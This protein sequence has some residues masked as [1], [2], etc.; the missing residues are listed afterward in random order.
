MPSII[1]KKVSPKTTKSASQTKPQI[2]G[3]A[4]IPKPPKPPKLA[5]PSVATKKV[6]APKASSKQAQVIAILS[7]PQGAK[8]PELMQ[9]TGWQAHSV[10]DFLSGTIKKKLNLNLISQKD[11]GAQI[12]RIASGD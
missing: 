8:L 12:Y 9:A 7:N 3:H 6:D 10:R 1:K 4:P 5:S 2:T 11:D